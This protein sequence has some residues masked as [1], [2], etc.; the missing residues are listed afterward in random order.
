MCNFDC[1]PIEG[2]QE[3]KIKVV[4]CEPGKP[5]KVAEIANTLKSFQNA[6]QGDIEAF[7]PFD[8][9]VCIHIT[10]Y[11]TLRSPAQPNT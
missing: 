6:V 10:H 5:A 1:D 7:Y 2:L 4:F 11:Y 9:Q 8:E 3:E